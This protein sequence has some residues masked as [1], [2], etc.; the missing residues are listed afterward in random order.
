MGELDAQVLALLHSSADRR[1][2][3]LV[4]ICKQSLD[5]AGGEHVGKD[6]PDVGAGDQGV[7]LGCTCG[8]TGKTV[9]WI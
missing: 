5:V 4:R 8:R 3:K 9:A 1:V 6:D 2:R 7:R